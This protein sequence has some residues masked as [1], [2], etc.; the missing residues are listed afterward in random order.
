MKKICGDTLKIAVESI[1]SA[2]RNALDLSSLSSGAP[3]RKSISSDR[4]AGSDSDRKDVLGIEGLFHDEVVGEIGLVHV[5]GLVSTM[6]SL[7]NLIEEFSKGFVGIFIASNA[8][9]GHDEWVAGVVDASLDGIIDGEAGFGLSG[10][11]SL[12]ELGGHD[13]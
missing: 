10:S 1:K 8:A 9:D 12:V 2:D 11:H 6:S 7:D 5:S 13:F 4:S 3:W